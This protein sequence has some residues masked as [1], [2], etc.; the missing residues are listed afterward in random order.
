MKKK[1]NIYNESIICDLTLP[2]VPEAENKDK[3]LN[4]YYNSNFSFVSLSVGVERM[5]ADQTI[6]YIKDVKN[7][8]KKNKNYVYVDNVD[9][10]RKSKKLNKLSLGFHFQGSEMLG[11][12]VENVKLFY[13]LG[14]RHMLLA[15]DYRSKAAD[16]CFETANAGLSIFGKSLIK[17]MNKVGMIIDLT[18][19]GY[20]SSI[21]AIELSTKPVIFSHSNPYKL[22]KT[23]RNITDEQI[24]KCAKTDGL[25][26]IVGFGHFLKNNDISP[27]NFVKNIDYIADLVG[28]R[29]IG[30]GLDYVYYQE[31]FLR[32]VRSNK[33]GLP[34][35]YLNNMKGFI[36]FEP[37]KIFDVTNILIRKNYSKKDI[38]GI[39]GEN[40]L[41]VAK[42]NWK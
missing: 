8:I 1:L 30:L 34:K 17:A 14:I 31:Q 40:F 7:Y 19:T 9:K 5:N 10:I 26:G 23:N 38:K 22:K 41:R 21:E 35:E 15:K 32:Q 28:P 11:G 13:D 3:I 33:F 27:E 25:I 6:R 24:K 20:K 12:K 42:K 29:H 37:E 36:Y 2:W 39:L 16:G 4:R 18:H